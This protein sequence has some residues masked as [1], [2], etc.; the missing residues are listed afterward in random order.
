MHPLLLAV[1]LSS[2]LARPLFLLQQE[3]VPAQTL[4]T[5]DDAFLVVSALDR[6]E[7]VERYQV[8]DL[9]ARNLRYRK[10]SSLDDQ[11]LLMDRRSS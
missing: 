4:Q 6:D 3:P 1:L 8:N 5:N 9:L 10:D 11:V 7:F 2:C